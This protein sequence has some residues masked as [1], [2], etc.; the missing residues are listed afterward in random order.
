MSN[1]PALFTGWPKIHRLSRD[2][3]ITEKIDGTNAQVYI[4]EDGDVH[5]GSRTRWIT[6]TSDNFGFA[7]WVE[8][9]KADL[10]NLGPGRHYGEWFGKGIQ[11]GYGLQVRRFA[12]FNVIR[13]YD[14][15][16]VYNFVNATDACPKCC[17]VVP[18]LFAGIFHSD[19]IE[20]TMAVLGYNGSCAAHNF[21]NPEGVVIY[22]TAANV[23]FKKTFANDA[24]GKPE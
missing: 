14:N 15:A 22:H 7:A 12:L 21:M 8:A 13:W 11:R 24:K 10:L 2:I 19:N 6:P 23:S 4:D 3:I 1:P 5:A 18:T 9:N 16:G 17:T 20:Q